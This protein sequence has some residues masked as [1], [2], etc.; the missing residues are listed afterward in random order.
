MKSIR[1]DL[2]RELESAELLVLAD[3]HYADPNSDHDAIKRDI[4]YVAQHDNAYAVF[5]D[6]GRCVCP[7][8]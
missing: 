6:A 4:D 2:P 3:Y 7:T 5:S 1:A 8:M